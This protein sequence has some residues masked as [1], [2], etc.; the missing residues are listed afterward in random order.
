M[1]TMRSGFITVIVTVALVST[2]LAQGGISANSDRSAEDE[3]KKLEIEINDLEVHGQWDAY[4]AHLAADYSLGG[5]KLQTREEVLAELRGGESTILNLLPEDL[6]VHVYGDT[7]VLTGHLT[8][9]VRQSGRVTT[10]FYQ[11]TD[12]FLRRDGRWYLVSTQRSLTKE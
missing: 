2:V 7:A 1:A 3:V 4:A 8:A 10:R 12:V 9:L 5:I 11:F 6:R